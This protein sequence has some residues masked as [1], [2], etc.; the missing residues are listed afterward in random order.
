[1][2][3]KKPCWGGVSELAIEKEVKARIPSMLRGKVESLI[4]TICRESGTIMQE[5]IYFSH[6]SRDFAVSDEAL[7]VRVEQSGENKRAILTYK[8]P[9]EKAAVKARE[10]INISIKEDEWK[11]LIRLL[12]KL[13]FKEKA[14]VRKKRV[15]FDCEWFKACIDSVDELGLFLEFELVEGEEKELLSLL[16]LLGL[17]KYVEEKTYLELLLEKKSG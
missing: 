14:V 8:G 2:A 15:E 16:Q 17:E 4:R 1:V 3:I 7:R 9:R 10:E 12:K 13:G 6:P 11:N 5:D